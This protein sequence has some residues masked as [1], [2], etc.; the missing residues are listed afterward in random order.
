[1][2]ITPRY[3]NETVNSELKRV[4]SRSPLPCHPSKQ[5]LRESNSTSVYKSSKKVKKEVE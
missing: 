4:S 1:M 5:T 3:R 2:D